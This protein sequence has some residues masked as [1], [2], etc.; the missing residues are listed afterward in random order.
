MIHTL[1]KKNKSN[2]IDKSKYDLM[3]FLA[4]GN[5]LLFLGHPVQDGIKSKP[6]PN[7]QYII[8]V[9]E[10]WFLSTRMP[11]VC[12]KYSMRDLI[13]LVIGYIV[14]CLK[15]RYWPIKCKW[16]TYTNFHINDEL[17]VDFL[18]CRGKLM[19]EESADEAT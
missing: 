12:I 3:R 11:W 13:C 5:G 7:S 17:G 19:Q 16:H 2:V 4:F 6:L 9:T 14:L 10:A 15:L 8:P 18:E 1:I